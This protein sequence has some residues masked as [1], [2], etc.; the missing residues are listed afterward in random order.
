MKSLVPWAIG[1]RLTDEMRCQRACQWLSNNSSNG[2]K[3]GSMHQRSKPAVGP[4]LAD[5]QYSDHSLLAR[6]CAVHR[7]GAQYFALCLQTLASCLCTSIV[8]PGSMRRT[9][10]IC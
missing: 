10:A 1:R 3:G 2:R 5:A 8:K 6:T 4:T 9:S 7:G